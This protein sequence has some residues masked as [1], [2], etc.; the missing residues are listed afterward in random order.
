MSDRPF[1]VVADDAGHPPLR[2]LAPPTVELYEEV[3]RAEVERRVRHAEAH[4]PSFSRGSVRLVGSYPTT[5]IVIEGTLSDKP[6]RV[7]L[8]LYRPRFHRMRGGRL[9]APTS[10]SWDVGMMFT[11]SRW[12]LLPDNDDAYVDRVRWEMVGMMRA[13]GGGLRRLGRPEVSGEGR[14]RRVCLELMHPTGDV[15]VD[16]A[17]WQDGHRRE[18][19][20]I[21]EELRDAALAAVGADAVEEEPVLTLGVPYDRPADFAAASDLADRLK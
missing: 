18:I 9:P 3:C 17:V 6:A 16:A 4:D 8:E 20:Q 5:C 7:E 1:R 2:T 14:A 11:E 15:S 10:W 19:W 13:F 21:A 12:W